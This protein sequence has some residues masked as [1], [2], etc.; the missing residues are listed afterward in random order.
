MVSVNSFSLQTES[1][2]SCYWKLLEQS[3]LSLALEIFFFFYFQ[4]LGIAKYYPEFK[5]NIKK[6]L[7][8]KKKIFLG[9]E[10]PSPVSSLQRTFV[11]SIRDKRREEKI[12]CAGA[13]A[14]TA[15]DPAAGNWLQQQQQF[16]KGKPSLVL[17]FQTSRAAFLP[18]P[19]SWAFLRSRFT[20]P[21]PW[22][23]P[24]PS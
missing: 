7:E 21:K 9:L 1:K 10:I 12:P 3:S 5:L 4:L 23:P 18:A 19:F 17:C 11:W 15:A 2:L 16:L 13:A 24:L 6:F 14:V 22:F 8:R 20:T